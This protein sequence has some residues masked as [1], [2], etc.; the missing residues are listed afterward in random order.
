LEG[1]LQKDVQEIIYTEMDRLLH[2]PV[3]KHLVVQKKR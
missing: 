2:D 3:M 1:C